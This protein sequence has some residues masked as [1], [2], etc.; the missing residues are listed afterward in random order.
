MN[1]HMIKMVGFQMSFTPTLT[2][3]NIQTSLIHKQKLAV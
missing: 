1:D 3:E 2:A